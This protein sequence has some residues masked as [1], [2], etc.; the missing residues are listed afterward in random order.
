LWST[1]PNVPSSAWAQ[2]QLALE[3]RYQRALQGEQ[4]AERSLLEMKRQG[5]LDEATAQRWLQAMKALFPDVREGSRITGLN[6]PGVGAQFFVD[7]QLK[8]AVNE[9]DFARRFFGIWLAPQSSD[10]ALRAALLGDP[11]ASPGAAR[12]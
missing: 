4:I 11:P 10:P 12:P 2:Q 1:G 3:I 9:V 8:G 6:R 5:D 7:G